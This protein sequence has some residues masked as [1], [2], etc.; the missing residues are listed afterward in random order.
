MDTA[1]PGDKEG[2]HIYNKHNGDHQE[3]DCCIE[4]QNGDLEDPD[5]NGKLREVDLAPQPEITS[6]YLQ[7]NDQESGTIIDQQAAG[8]HSVSNGTESFFIAQKLQQLENDLSATK[9]ELRGMKEKLTTTEMDRDS[10]L[11]QLEQTENKLTKEM[12]IIQQE[13][14]VYKQEVKKNEELFALKLANAEDEIKFTKQQLAS[15]DQSLTKAEKKY[16]SL[17]ANS[18][19]A[20]VKLE[21][22][23]LKMIAET[24]K[25]SDSKIT[26]LA[27]EL[28]ERMQQVEMVLYWA[29]RINTEAIKSSLHTQVVPVILKMSDY[30]TK[31]HHRIDWYSDPFYTHQKGYKM[32]LN[33]FAAGLNSP[34]LTVWLHLVKGSYDNHLKWPLKGKCEVKLLNQVNNCEHHCEIGTIE[35]G[36]KQPS[37]HKKDYV[38]YNYEFISHEDLQ[39][40]TSSC[41]YLKDDALFFQVQCK[42]D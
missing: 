1:T 33:V 15:A 2:G 6:S 31:K 3:D 14:D 17:A 13:V 18:D 12:R 37:P 21:T 28:Q 39:T 8:T 27:G 42:L 40:T 11:H 9:L 4:H 29:I 30:S 5:V 23:F 36:G 7:E 41:Q 10:L 35:S 16:S 34:H 19:E 24:E 32:C 26:E 38:W 25:I 20:L 22:R